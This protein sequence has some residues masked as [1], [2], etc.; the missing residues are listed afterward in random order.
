MLS[1]IYIIINGGKIMLHS[2]T[3]EIDTDTLLLRRFRMSDRDDMLR[4]WIADPAVQHEY[5]EPIY[6]RR[7]K[8]M[9]CSESGHQPM[10]VLTSTAG[11]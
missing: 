11:Q 3:F 4:N 7:K 5:G 6:Q 10:S 2:G 9:R 1:Y 8:L